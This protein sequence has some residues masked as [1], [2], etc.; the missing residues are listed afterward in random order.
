MCE[1]DFLYKNVLLTKRKAPA[2]L[3]QPRD[4][5]FNK[6]RKSYRTDAPPKFS[7]KIIQNGGVGHAFNF[8][9]Q[10]KSDET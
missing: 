2:T 6:K 7:K 4:M 10:S 3:G 5:L 8:F 9:L 1:K